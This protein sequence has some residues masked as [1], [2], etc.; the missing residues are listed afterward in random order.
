MS[1]KQELYAVL[2]PLKGQKADRDMK[3]VYNKVTA[4]FDNLL[5]SRGLHK[6]YFVF[7]HSNS[8]TGVRWFDL[9][10]EGRSLEDDRDLASLSYNF[11]TIF[12]T[13]YHPSATPCSNLEYYS[14]QV[15]LKE[16]DG[17]SVDDPNYFDK[18][19]ETVKAKEQADR[20]DKA[21]FKDFCRKTFD[22]LVSEFDFD[23]LGLSDALTAMRDEYKQ[24]RKE[25][26]AKNN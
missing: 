4:F 22:Q 19:L 18:L 14:F 20:A 17:I 10:F 8:T 12:V 16:L 9:Y 26:K 25:L 13:L 3:D 1:M 7:A 5:E 23:P 24:Y 11:G 2:E 15:T 21:A 6:R